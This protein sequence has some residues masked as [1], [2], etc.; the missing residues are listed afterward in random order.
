M[1]VG[2]ARHDVLLAAGHRPGTAA[3]I[4]KTGGD[5]FYAAF[6][7]AMDA[8][9]ATIAA[10]QALTAEPWPGGAVIRVRMGLHTGRCGAAGRR[11][12]RP[13]AQSRS[14]G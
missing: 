10:Q 3:Y 7:S 11:L 5:A 1:R 2:L 14:P 6:G 9:A 13:A 12:F 8:V 4:F